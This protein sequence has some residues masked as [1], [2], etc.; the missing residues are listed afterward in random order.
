MV[1]AMVACRPASQLE[2]ASVDQIGVWDE[3]SV[4]SEP[5]RSPCSKFLLEPRP[6]PP[7]GGWLASR[8]FLLAVTVLVGTLL[9]ALLGKDP[10]QGL[11]VFL[12]SPFAPPMPGPT[13]REGHAAGVDSAGAGCAFAPT[14]EYRGRGAIHHGAILQVGC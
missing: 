10:V 13:Q 4:A 14:P 11:R 12:G 1:M 7:R 5:W 2:H 8:R 3:R 9:F 6:V